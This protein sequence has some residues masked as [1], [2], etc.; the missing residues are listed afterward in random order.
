MLSLSD[1]FS[2]EEVKEFDKRVRSVVS[3]PE[4]MC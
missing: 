2:E 4:Y 3:N 1:V